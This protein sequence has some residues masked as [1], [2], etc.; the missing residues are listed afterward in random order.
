MTNRLAIIL[1]L[2]IIGG[3]VADLMLNDGVALLFLA[4]KFAEF[5]EWIAF[6]R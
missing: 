4:K 3:I 1:G 2:L 5:L 6:W